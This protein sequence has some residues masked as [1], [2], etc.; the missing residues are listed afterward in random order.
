MKT[1]KRFQAFM[2]AAVMAVVGFATPAFAAEAEDAVVAEAEETKQVEVEFEVTPDM[3]DENGMIAIP[4][5]VTSLVD[6]T[7]SFTNYHRGADRKYY[8]TT[9]QFSVTITGPNNTYP[10]DAV[11]IDLK[12][13]NGNTQ[14][15]TAYADGAT[16]FFSTSIVYGRT[17]YFYYKNMSSST[18]TLTVHMVIN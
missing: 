13:Y 9:L 12:D 7:F 16:Y 8:Q 11:A 1:F 3:I 6:Q 4:A 17:Y 18:R 10:G 14:Y 5:S 15:F 2:L